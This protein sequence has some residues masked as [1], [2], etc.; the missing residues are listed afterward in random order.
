[1]YRNLVGLKF[2]MLTVVGVSHKDCKNVWWNCVCEC[3]GS[4]VSTS[5]N[6]VHG[7][8]KSCGCLVHRSKQIRKYDARF[9]STINTREKA[10]LLGLFV[11]DGSLGVRT[12]TGVLSEFYFVSMDRQL[13]EMFKDCLVFDGSIGIRKD[14]GAFYIAIGNKKLGNDL[15]ALGI[16]N[17]K[18]SSA[19]YPNILSSLDSHFIRGVLD[20]DGW[21]TYQTARNGSKHLAFG[22]V[23][24]KTLIE[25]INLRLPYHCYVGKI[26]NCYRL[27]CSYRKA[28]ENL[29]WLYNDSEQL[30]LERKYERFLLWR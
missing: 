26:G 1:M 24:T 2:G 13:V 10:Y 15:V 30:R 22:I 21:V 3:G 29:A 14:S 27:L 4:R 11:A 8:N 25:E 28:R 18:S 19:V 9:F 17:D 12:S 5:G 20:G 16:R 23:G 7:G 6:L